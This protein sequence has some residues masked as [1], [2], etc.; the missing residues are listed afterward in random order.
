MRVEPSYIVGLDGCAAGRT[1]GRQFLAG[2]QW[3][4]KRRPS[5]GT[6]SRGWP[7]PRWNLSQTPLHF[8]AEYGFKNVVELLLARGANVNAEGRD[9]V[10][11]LHK[12]AN[13]A[14]ADVLI[15][16][17]ADINAKGKA[18]KTPL[19]YAIG[20]RRNEIAEFLIARGAD[21]NAK[22]NADQTLLEFAEGHGQTEIVELLKKH[23]AKE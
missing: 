21:V 17:G 22:N 13:S 10:T 7:S 12:A 20:N 3:P 14:V 4:G 15:A 8:A 19:H 2:H 23:G 6:C 5:G 1:L 18:D 16:K 11:P 9:G